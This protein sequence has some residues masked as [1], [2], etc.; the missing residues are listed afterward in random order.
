MLESIILF[1]YKD[2]IQLQ[3]IT[4]YLKLVSY[5]LINLNHKT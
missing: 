3:N 2:N 4:R 5:T 1:K